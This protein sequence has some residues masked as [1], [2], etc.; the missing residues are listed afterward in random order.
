MNAVNLHIVC[1]TCQG[2]Q[3][4]NNRKGKDKG[5]D[6]KPLVSVHDE[7]QQESPSDE[8]EEIVIETEP[9]LE[10]SD[11]PEDVSDASDSVDC[12]PEISQPD[13]DERD[14]SPVNW[15]SDT[16]EIHPPAEASSSGLSVPSTVLHGAIE[17]NNPSAMDDS[18]STCSTDSVP[19]VSQNGPYKGNSFSNQKSPKSPSR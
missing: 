1:S 19:S 11:S 7:L 4:R 18:S 12:P 9:V 16:S 10:K 8:R 6:D 17:R 5:R 14:V 3:K 2:K 13:S 15:G